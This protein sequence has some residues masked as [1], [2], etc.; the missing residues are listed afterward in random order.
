MIPTHSPW[1]AAHGRL[2]YDDKW[3]RYGWIIWPQ[4]LAAVLLLWLWAA[5]STTRSAQW[6][7]PVD[8]NTRSQ[9]LATLRDTAKSDQQ[10][11]DRLEAAARGGEMSAQFYLGTLY[12]PDLKLSKVVAPSFDQS[13][14]WYAKAASQGHQ[15]ALNNLALDY[16]SGKYT[17]VDYTRACYYALKML[18]SAPGNG[19][20]V[21]GDCYA[22]G[23]GG[24]RP[25]PVQAEAAY[26]AATANGATR[27][28]PPP[29]APP[30]V[31]SLPPS[32]P[33]VAPPSFDPVPF[34]PQPPPLNPP[35]QQPRDDS[36]D[37]QWGAMAFTADGSYSTVWRMHSQPEAE[38]SVA[39]QCAE[40]G[41]GGCRVFSISGQECAS[42]ATYSSRRNSSS[43]SAG[44]MTYPEAQNN[45]LE[46][47]NSDGRNRGRC[48]SRNTFCADGR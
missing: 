28:A 27:T 29:S 44:G 33:S 30:I 14:D 11:M 5:P 1:L 41:R 35:P 39:K 19:L 18:P 16:S 13:A 10:A 20:N 24:T 36:S 42:L 26:K 31:P 17:R 6:G 37:T 9:Q 45:A 32:V 34:K 2:W 25:D 22:R 7:V 4:A 40:F 46:R 15:I 47:C 43:Y 12:D 8:S 21:K 38:A 48:K 3:Y 23:L